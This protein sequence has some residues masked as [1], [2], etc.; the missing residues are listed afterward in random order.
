MKC[1]CCKKDNERI[2]FR[3]HWSKRYHEFICGNCKTEFELIF[4]KINIQKEVNLMY[5]KLIEF[6]YYDEIQQIKQKV[7]N[8]NEDQLKE[9]LEEL[10]KK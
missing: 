8:M 7:N 1:P 3:Q 9:R 2:L 6:E 4:F 10:K 5:N